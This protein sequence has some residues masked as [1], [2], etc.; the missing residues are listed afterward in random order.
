M[1]SFSIVQS[2]YTIFQNK[3]VSNLN[4]EYFWYEI[5]NDFD[6]EI[7]FK[8]L[9]HAWNSLWYFKKGKWVSRGKP[10]YVKW[11]VS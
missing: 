7:V 9:T 2:N 3:N 1:A 6:V 11:Q 4:G 10:Y 5:K 8:S